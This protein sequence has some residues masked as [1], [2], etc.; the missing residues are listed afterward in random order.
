ML[1]RGIRVGLGMD[2]AASSGMIDM[3]AEMREALLLSRETS[4]PLGIG[5]VW[6]MATRTDTLPSL[7]PNTIEIGSSPRAM[8]VRSAPTYEALTAASPR[9]VMNL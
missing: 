2:S 6:T 9:D 4:R 1:D 7:P 5:E 8:L 3:F